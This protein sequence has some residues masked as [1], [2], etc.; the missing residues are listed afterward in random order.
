MN[1]AS[2]TQVGLKATNGDFFE[3]TNEAPQLEQPDVYGFDLSLEQ[4]PQL[5]MDDSSLDLDV[6]L[7]NLHS[8]TVET[9]EVDLQGSVFIVSSSERLHCT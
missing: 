8:V 2:E 4:P 5:A 1:H 7:V 3:P 9:V 6:L